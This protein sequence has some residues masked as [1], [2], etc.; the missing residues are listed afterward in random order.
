MSAATALPGLFL[1]FLLLHHHDLVD[2]LFVVVVVVVVVGSSGGGGVGGVLHTSSLDHKLR[3]LGRQCIVRLLGFLRWSFVRLRHGAAL[4][5]FR[6]QP[7]FQV[8]TPL[9]T[10][11]D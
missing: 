11:E 8:D 5:G 10:R 7:S 9:A 3:C 2:K 1:L 4:V 6:T